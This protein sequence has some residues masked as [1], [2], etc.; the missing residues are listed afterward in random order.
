MRRIIPAP[1]Q[2]TFAN[3]MGATTIPVASSH[4]AMLSH[5]KVVADAILAAVDSVK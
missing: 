2:L 4:V 3:K 1:L 5:P